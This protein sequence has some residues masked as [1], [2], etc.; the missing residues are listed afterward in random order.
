MIEQKQEWSNATKYVLVTEHSY[1][2]IYLE[3]VEKFDVED[4]EKTNPI[5]E[6]WINGIWVD[7]DYRHQGYATKLL[8]RADEIIKTSE[9]N[10]VYIQLDFNNDN[11]EIAKKMFLKRGFE[12]I[13]EYGTMVNN[14][15][16]NKY[17]E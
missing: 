3:E 11:W 15:L 7:E 9:Y 13:D 5:K 1:L 12:T 14:Y 2:S 8:N 4:E 6:A 16:N 10:K 17:Y